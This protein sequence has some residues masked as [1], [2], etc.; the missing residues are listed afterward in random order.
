MKIVGLVFYLLC[1]LGMSSCRYWALEDEYKM[2]AEGRQQ[3]EANDLHYVGTNQAKINSLALANADLRDEDLQELRGSEQ[4]GI[5]SGMQLRP[6]DG[7]DG[8]R[9]RDEREGK[10]EI[11]NKGEGE[12]EHKNIGLDISQNDASGV[13]GSKAENTS[14]PKLLERIQTS[15]E[16]L[17]NELSQFN[18]TNLSFDIPFSK[19][20]SDFNSKD[21]QDEVYAGLGHD[22]E[23]IEKLG[24][25]FDRLNLISPPSSSRR[26][27]ASHGVL[28]VLSNLSHRLKEALNHFSDEVLEKIRN[29]K[30]KDDIDLIVDSLDNI[31]KIRDYLISKIRDSVESVESVTD[32]E[33]IIDVLNKDF[34][35]AKDVN[36]KVSA[37]REFSM[38]ITNA[39]KN[40]E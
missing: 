28:S 13:D 19:I 37:L 1:A 14:Y 15:K 30:K 23:L 21:K 6:E 12:G 32:E 22:A 39:V 18:L 16:K 9:N 27:K 31:M 2:G 33:A 26:T 5:S 24:G 11:K 20:A 10:I 36:Y 8:D 17:E 29:H 38:A 4:E 40:L 7:V 25:I 35:N 34:V 3:D